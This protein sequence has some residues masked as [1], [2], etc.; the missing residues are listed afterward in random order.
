MQMK[1]REKIDE[2]TLLE[3]FW[4]EPK[5]ANHEYGYWCYEATDD[6]GRVIRFCMDVIQESVQIDLKVSGLSL[7]T[8]SFELVDAIEI[9]DFDRGQFAFVVAPDIEQARTR[10][11]VKLR[12]DIEVQGYTLKNE[13]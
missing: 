6:A 3:L 10:I 4:S 9:I 11:E 13:S 12:P 2:L 5:I 8:L 7:V 1:L